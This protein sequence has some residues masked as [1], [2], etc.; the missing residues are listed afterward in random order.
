MLGIR[1]RSLNEQLMVE[2]IEDA[3]QPLNLKEIADKICEENE[4]SLTGKTPEKS[5][6]SIVYRR[7]NKRKEVGIPPMFVVTKRGGSKYYS[8]NKGNK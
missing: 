1:N 6:Y 2:I 8:V 5:L 7:E 3:G 4:T